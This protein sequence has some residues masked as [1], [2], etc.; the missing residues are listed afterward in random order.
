MKSYASFFEWYDKG[1]KELGV[2]EELVEALKQ[3]SARQ[4]HSPSAYTPDPPDCLCKNSAGQ[5]IAIEV[6][7]VVCQDAVRL[8]AQGHNVFRQWKPGELTAHIA[9][10]LDKKDGKSFHGGPYQEIIVCLFTDE[11][12]LTVPQA[13]AELA[14]QCFGPFKLL[15]SAYLLFSYDPTSQTYPFIKLAFR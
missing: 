6:A 10:V 4:L 9:H 11:P 12:M 7:E 2:V 13:R 8:N 3:C 1:R 5:V 14:G 15:T